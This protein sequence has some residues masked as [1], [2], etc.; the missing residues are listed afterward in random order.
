MK[1]ISFAAVVTLALSGL[2][3]ADETNLR[4]GHAQTPDEAKA[5]LLQFQASYSD[6]G[7]WEKRKE[8]ILEGILEGASL[9]KLPEK[10]PLNPRFSNKRSYE[11]YFVESVAFESSPG[12]YVTGTLYRPSEFK[13]RLA[14]MVM[15]GVL[16]IIDKSAVRFWRAWERP[17]FNTI[18]WGMAIGRR[19]G[20][21]MTKRRK[22]SDC[23]P[24]IVCVQ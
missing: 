6:L 10:T 23:R 15:G 7:G 11:G 1:Y 20:G 4:R 9:S 16:T 3:L 21:L 19:R 17:Y 14:G 5:E 13:G 2:A 24:G 22:Y 12:I 18:W 8:N